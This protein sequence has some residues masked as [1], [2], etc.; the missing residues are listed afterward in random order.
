M[1]SQYFRY[2]DFFNCGPTQQILKLRN[3]PLEEATWD[4]IEALAQN[5]L[6]PV[7]NEFGP[8]ILTF[9]FCSPELARE[10]KKRPNP[11]ISPKHD[12]HSGLELNRFGKLICERGGFAVDFKSTKFSSYEISKW[13]YESLNFDRMYLYGKNSP[14]HISYSDKNLKSLIIMKTINNRR[15]PCAIKNH[16]KAHEF[17][18]SAD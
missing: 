6:D 8:I 5:I 9:A 17:F 15:I 1:C 2:L 14:L 12:Q 16:D 11:H 10:I 4:A 13:I 7:V 18:N 3:T